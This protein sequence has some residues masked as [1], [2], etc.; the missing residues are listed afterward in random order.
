MFGETRS[1]GINRI[2][3]V[4]RPRRCSAG[5]CRR[6]IFA[7][8]TY[9]AAGAAGLGVSPVCALETIPT[10]IANNGSAAWI[11]RSISGTHNS[12]MGCTRKVCCCFRGRA[13]VSGLHEAAL[14]LHRSGSC[15]A[16]MWLDFLSDA[17]GR[18]SSSYAAVPPPSLT[19]IL[20]R[21]NMSQLPGGWTT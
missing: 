2:G 9:I 4:D 7:L 12:P 19:C 16:K 14:K 15:L 10:E 18:I 20:H 3:C 13:A 11:S 17:S 8:Q 21:T 1:L 6:W 5:A